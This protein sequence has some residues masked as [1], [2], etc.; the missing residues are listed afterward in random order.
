MGAKSELTIV[1]LLLSAQK[2]FIG[3]KDRLQDMI[4]RK[5]KPILISLILCFTL[6]NMVMEGKTDEEIPITPNNEFF[7]VA[8]DFFDINPDTYRLI[9]TGEVMNPL[10]LSLTEIKSMPV[11]SEIV[12]LTCIMYNRKVPEFASLTGVANWTG[13]QLS[14]ILNLARINFE[15]VLDISLHT[16]D[17]HG[18]SA[19]STSLD[20]TEAF[21]EDVILAYEMN[22]EPLPAEHGFPIRLV[23]PRFFGYK[24]IKWL[25]YI[26]V[27][28]DNYLGYYERKGFSDSPFVDVPL[29]IYYTQPESQSPES[30]A[31]S[32]K[33]SFWP[34]LEIF[35]AMIVI[36]IIPKFIKHFLKYRKK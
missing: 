1:I 28:T 12:R 22:G 13:V 7:K 11:T 30:Q 33:T 27:T 6:G 32:Q 4:R 2:T 35:L 31:S 14:Y 5:I 19:Y 10:N 21:W 3:G 23:C 17:L 24:W 15:T 26:N 25:Q 20:V 29:P 36:G 9:V 8:I 18:E 34:R 16:P